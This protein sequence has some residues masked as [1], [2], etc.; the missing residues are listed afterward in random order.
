M[1]P[2]YIWL[3]TFLS[4]CAENSLR[5]WNHTAKCLVSRGVMQRLPLAAHR[6]FGS[7]KLRAYTRDRHDLLH[8]LQRM[9]AWF[10]NGIT[11]SRPSSSSPG[12][13]VHVFG[14]GWFHPSGHQLLYWPGWS[15]AAT[16]L[17]IAFAFRCWRWS[18]CMRRAIVPAWWSAYVLTGE[19]FTNI[20]GSVDSINPLLAAKSTSLIR[21]PASGFQGFTGFIGSSSKTFT[22]C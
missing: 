8:S 1:Q 11:W 4:C 18:V 6:F 19:G 10:D 5:P 22:G 12:G 2:D 7:L 16:R 15:V 9:R 3:E 14:F 20:G 17:I 13:D 21:W